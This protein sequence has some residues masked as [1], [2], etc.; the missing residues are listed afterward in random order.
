M[1]PYRTM[2]YCLSIFGGILLIS[3]LAWGLPERIDLKFL[4]SLAFPVAI[5]LAGLLWSRYRP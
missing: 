1:Y 2:G 4:I 5:V 3:G